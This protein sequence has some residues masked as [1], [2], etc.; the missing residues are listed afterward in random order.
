MKSSR[1]L[2][3]TLFIA[4]SILG[5]ISLGC[6]RSAGPVLE[7]VAVPPATNTTPAPSQTT[8]A[9]ES[10]LAMLPPEAIKK[11]Q[12]RIIAADLRSL[13]GDQLQLAITDLTRVDSIE[14][15][16]IGGEHVNDA[17][18]EPIVALPTLRRL[19]LP[20]SRITDATLRKLAQTKQLEL[21]DL[22]DVHSISDSGAASI[23]EMEHLKELN[24]MNTPF[25]DAALPS[26]AKLQA[27]RKLRLRGTKVT[28]EHAE[29][30]A[31]MQVVDLELSETAFGNSGMEAISRMPKLERLNLWLTKID[32][33]G[34]AKLQGK[35]SL[36]LLNLDNVAGVT[37]ESLSVLEQLN[38]LQLLH[39]GGTGITP[40]GV[41]RL[42]KLQKLETLFITRLG[43]DRETAEALQKELPKLER[44]EY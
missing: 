6:N 39:L 38:K 17:R 26:L 2:L 16:T 9:I 29:A 32:D 1:R 34:L 42:A 22:T 41:S 43:V 28:G 19:R 11:K 36:T 7:Q 10:L 30:I 20:Q 27:L 37:D 8:A 23:G 44:F 5:C 3:E 31:M 18:V 4:I 24:L 15:V 14:E 12:D 40:S 21:L 13:T 25:T 35:T 33:V